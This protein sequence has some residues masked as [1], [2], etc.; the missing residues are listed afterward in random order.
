[1]MPLMLHAAAIRFDT[2]HAILLIRRHILIC[3][4]LRLRHASSPFSADIAAII[5]FC[6]FAMPPP[7]PIRYAYAA[8]D[9]ALRADV[10]HT[11][12]AMLDMPL[13][14]FSP[15]CLRYDD[16]TMLMLCHALLPLLPCRQM[17]HTPR[18]MRRR[19]APYARESSRSGARALS[20]YIMP[21]DIASHVFIFKSQ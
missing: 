17:P 19:A 11:R 4:L 3:R 16:V 12:Y 6:A 5:I 18:Y 7:L 1:M 15:L 20:Y 13:L 14:I 8:I 2:C 9:A 21:R 10:F